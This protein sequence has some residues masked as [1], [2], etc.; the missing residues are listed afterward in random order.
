MLNNV[1]YTYSL[2]I[3]GYMNK[4]NGN[5]IN[6]SR[7]SVGRTITYVEI[8]SSGG[9]NQLSCWSD[10]VTVNKHISLEIFSQISQ[11]LIVCNL[12]YP[13][14]RALNKG[15]DWNRNFSTISERCVPINRLH[16]SDLQVTTNINHDSTS[17]LIPGNLLAC[18][19]WPKSILTPFCFNWFSTSK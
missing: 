9:Y 16:V 15:D 4:R 1:C 13:K 14:S 12:I 3:A 2:V 6:V 5:V 18:S 8:F 10:E 11:V 7:L 19:K 17:D